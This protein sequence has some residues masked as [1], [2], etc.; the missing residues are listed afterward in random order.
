MRTFS[1]YKENPE[2]KPGEEQQGSCNCWHWWLLPSG[3]SLP[4]HN[5]LL[6]WFCG[7][8]S[9]SFGLSSSY[10]H[11]C[12]PKKI[13]SLLWI[14]A[15]P[16]TISTSK[17]STHSILLFSFYPEGFFGE[18]NPSYPFRSFQVCVFST[19]GISLYVL[20]VELCLSPHS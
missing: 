17:S 12:T 1:L 14:P 19:S 15:H 16:S 6:L 4:R 18:I 20:W 9:F 5:T 3:N 10:P 8:V 11:L 7:S 2:C 13:W